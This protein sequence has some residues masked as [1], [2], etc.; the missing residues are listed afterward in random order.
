MNQKAELK[1]R[2]MMISIVFA[3]IA[4][5]ILVYMLIAFRN[6]KDANGLYETYQMSVSSGDSAKTVFC[7]TFMPSDQTYVE[8]LTVGE[9]S[10]QLSKGTYEEKDGIVVLT[11]EDKDN[12]QSFAISGKY[13]VATDFLYDGDVPDGDTFEATC[14]YTN[15]NNATYTISF[16]K[17]GTYTLDDNGDSKDGTYKREGD[18]IKRTDSSGDGAIDYLVYKN[19]ITN[20]YYVA[21]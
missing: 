15:K 12:V 21:K 10:T 2:W 17:D 3:V 11:S 8:S 20:S 14:K 7:M 13:L 16:K 18:L 5:V 4:V 9:K 6:K 1:K 19:Q